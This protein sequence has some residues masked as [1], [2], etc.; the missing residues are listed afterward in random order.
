MYHAWAVGSSTPS[1]VVVAMDEGEAHGHGHERLGEMILGFRDVLTMPWGCSM[2]S[3]SAWD[4][5]RA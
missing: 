4:G 2:C 5:L 3:S 1:M